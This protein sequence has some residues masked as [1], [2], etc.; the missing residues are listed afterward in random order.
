[1]VVHI[2]NHDYVLMYLGGDNGADRVLFVEDGVAADDHDIRLDL[3]VQALG[4]R[5]CQL[6]CTGPATTAAA[7]SGPIP[8]CS[9]VKTD[10]RGS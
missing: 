10:K 4:R 2:A 7:L 9:S 3:L 5:R 6:R 1:M 8:A